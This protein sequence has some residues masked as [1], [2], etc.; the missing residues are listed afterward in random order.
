[1]WLIRRSPSPGFVP[2]HC[3]TI[4]LP[5]DGSASSTACARPESRRDDRDPQPHRDRGRRRS[6]AIP[7]DVRRRRASIAARPVSLTIDSADS[8]LANG[9]YPPSRSVA[10]NNALPRWCK[11]PHLH[12]REL[13]G[14]LTSAMHLPANCRPPEV[15]WILFQAL[16]SALERPRATILATTEIACWTITQRKAHGRRAPAFCGIAYAGI[17]LA[18]EDRALGAIVPRRLERSRFRRAVLSRRRSGSESG[19]D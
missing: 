13:A 15:F 8:A 4:W 16:V 18:S 11:N 6:W 9:S 7:P 1:L 14:R 19:V 2:G 10:P 12:Y 17:A 5:L 3:P